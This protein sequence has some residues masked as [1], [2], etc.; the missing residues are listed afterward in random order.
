[1]DLFWTGKSPYEIPLKDGIKISINVQHLKPL[2][3]FDMQQATNSKSP[4]FQKIFWIQWGIIGL[5][6]IA[7]IYT[8]INMLSQQIPKGGVKFRDSMDDPTAI[9]NV[10]KFR[11]I[12]FWTKKG[13]GVWYDTADLK[14]YVDSIYPRLVEA[15]RAWMGRRDSGID[16]KTDTAGYVWKLA[17]Y[18]M[19]TE[20]P[21]DGKTRPDY[22]VVPIFVRDGDTPDAKKDVI[23]YFDKNRP[24]FY[25]HAPAVNV[26]RKPNGSLTINNNATPTPPPPGGAFNT[27]TMF[28]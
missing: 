13:N 20:D 18:W 2:K 17:C 25:N 14:F 9:D 1:L 12:T 6:T 26:R 16:Y 4:S 11:N 27:G 8:I 15:Q 21:D 7:L 23:D 28:P 19:L 10:E 3:P 24:A 22:C 5:L